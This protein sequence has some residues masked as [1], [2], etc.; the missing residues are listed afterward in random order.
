MSH[1]STTAPTVA[2]TSEPI[3]PKEIIPN[4]RKRKPPMSAPRIPTTRSPTRPKPW[5]RVSLPESQPAA[6]PII[7]NHNQCMTPPRIF[8]LILSYFKLINF[9]GDVNQR[10]LSC[11]K[12]QLATTFFSA[13]M[14]TES[15]AIEFN[16]RRSL[17]VIKTLVLRILIILSIAIST[18][19][20]T[21]HGMGQDI[22]GAGKSI[23]R[24]TDK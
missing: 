1:R 15:N 2:D 18:G 5:P 21:V 10:G 12:R 4:K 8:F 3:S 22:E 13:T 20:H 16:E 11:E 17:I 7:K 6:T 24:A 14:E 9:C 19:C 23:E